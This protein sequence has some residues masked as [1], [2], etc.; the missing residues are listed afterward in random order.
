[1][2]ASDLP[3][4]SFV[5]TLVTSFT[6]HPEALRLL[7]E[8][9][10][11]NH[12][13]SSYIDA[14]AERLRPESKWKEIYTLRGTKKRTYTAPPNPN[15]GQV[16]GSSFDLI[17]L[18]R[19]FYDDRFRVA[20][21]FCGL[22]DADEHSMY[23]R[24]IYVHEMNFQRRV[25]FF[26]Q[27][28]DAIKWGQDLFPAMSEAVIASVFKTETDESIILSLYKGD[29]LYGSAQG[30]S[31]EQEMIFQPE[32]AD[33]RNAPRFVRFGYMLVDSKVQ[34]V[35]DYGEYI[36][37]VVGSLSRI[38]N[39]LPLVKASAASEGGEHA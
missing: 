5:K 21:A 8:N 4:D 17:S 33:Y 23:M 39:T 34:L 7:L 28:S 3:N 1:M 10:P 26:E 14:A 35:V 24:E 12:A 19:V 6:E 13:L 22:T 2:T 16:H 18:L 38:P 9:E 25:E 31:S 32:F 27:E 37:E 15:Y 20:V 11:M 29:G 30:Y 36:Y